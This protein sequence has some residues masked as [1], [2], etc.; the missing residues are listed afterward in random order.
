MR[1]RACSAGL[2]KPIGGLPVVI[3][4]VIGSPSA[5]LSAAVEKRRPAADYER[6]P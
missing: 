6:G 5:G 4:S 2:S 3:A 1:R